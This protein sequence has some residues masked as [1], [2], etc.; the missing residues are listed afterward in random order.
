MR[1]AAGSHRWM[2]AFRSHLAM[3]GAVI[4]MPVVCVPQAFG[5]RKAGDIDNDG[6]PTVRDLT[7]ITRH[8]SGVTVLPEA[9]RIYA[10]VNSDGVVN[11]ADVALLIEEI[12]ETREPQALPPCHVLRASPLDGEGDVAVTRETVVH[13]SMPLSPDATLD[14][15]SFWAEFGGRKILARAEIASD[16]LKA[17]LFYLEPLPSNARVEVNLVEPGLLD[18]LGRPVDFNLD[19][20][21]NLYTT[22][23][24]TITITPVEG[25][26]ISGRVFATEIGEG[27]IETPLAGVT[28]TVDGAEETLRTTTDG[29][30]NFT[31]S[32]CPAGSFFVKIDGRTSPSSSY[33]NGDFY[34]VVAKKWEAIAGRDDNLAVEGGTIY[35]PLIQSGTLQPASATE[36]TVIEFPAEVV[37]ENPEL[38]GVTIEVPPNALFS[39][40]GTRGGLVGIAPVASDRLPEPLPSG[41]TH[42]IDISIQTDGG[43]NFDRPVPV[44]FPNLPDPETGERLPP[45]AKSALWS[46]NHDLGEWEISG[47]MTVTDDGMYLKSDPGVGVLQPGWHGT[48]PGIDITFARILEAFLFGQ[49]LFLPQDFRCLWRKNTL[50]AVAEEFGNFRG[51]PGGTAAFA[52]LK[53]YLEGSGVSLTYEGLNNKTVQDVLGSTQ[54]RA[55]RS[56]VQGIVQTR[57]RAAHQIGKKTIDN[58]T[59]KYPEDIGN[60][61]FYSGELREKAL[62]AAFGGTQSEEYTVSNVV[63]FE[64]GSYSFQLKAEHG[65]RYEFDNDDKYKSPFDLFA[66]YLAKHCDAKPFDVKVI[67]NDFINGKVGGPLEMLEVPAPDSFG[68]ET[69]TSSFFMAYLPKEID[70]SNGVNSISVD[71]AGGIGLRNAGVLPGPIYFCVREAESKS[72]II[73]RTI[74]G[75]DRKSRIAV[76]SSKAYEVDIFAPRSG[77]IRSITVAPANPGGALRFDKIF[78]NSEP[79][80]DLIDS[81]EDLLSDVGESVIGTSP[82]NPD[83]DNDGIDDYTEVT[84]GTD[85]LSGLAARTGI[86]ASAP[87]RGSAID[88]AAA[89]NLAVTAN[90]AAGVTVFNIFAGLNPTRI[91]EVDTPGTAQRVSAADDLIAVADGVAGLAVV[92]VSD[93]PSAGIVHQVDLGSDAFSVATNGPIAFVGTGDGRVVRVNM[94]TGEIIDEATLAGS[95]PVLDLVIGGETLYA[96]RNTTLST[97]A[98]DQAELVV[99]HT[100]SA[101]ATVPTNNRWRRIFAT[102]E[103]L[104][105]NFRDGWQRFSLSNDPLLPQSSGMKVT[106]ARGWKQIVPNGSGLALACVGANPTATGPHHL[107]VYDVGADA[108]GTQ[109]LT[110]FETPGIAEAV[111]IANGLAYVADGIRGLQVVNYKAYDTLGQPPSVTLD[112]RFGLGAGTGAVDAGKVSRFTAT[113]ADDVQV[114]SVEFHI[115]D[116][117]AFTDVTYPFEHRFLPPS[118][119]S[120]FTIKARAVDTGGNAAWTDEYTISVLTE[121]VPPQLLP[122]SPA[123]GKV[124]PPK[125]S[126]TVRFSE[127]M[128]LVSLQNGGIRLTSAGPDG[129]FGTADDADLAPDEWRFVSEAFAAVLRFN[130]PLD[131]GLYRLEVTTAARDLAG[132]ALPAGS[133][134]EFRFASSL[135]SDNDGVPDDFESVL[136]LTVGE[137][138]SDL[139]GT[140]DG[141]ED[142]DNDGATNAEEYLLGFDPIDPDSDG[143]GVLDGSEDRDYDGLTDITELLGT[144]DFA[145]ADTDGDGFDDAT[146][147][148]AGMDPNG[149]NFLPAATSSDRVFILNAVPAPLPLLQVPTE[150][151]P[152]SFENQIPPP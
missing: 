61:N 131:P 33:P 46:F 59:L 38:A 41:L 4:A 31:L 5:Q 117:L 140:P 62:V 24:E 52:N 103:T 99:A 127:G 34:P 97:L 135:D 132:N 144:T 47:P 134:T 45:G 123:S 43:T 133:S 100:V 21:T 26:A 122:L 37:A 94:L 118:V 60:L 73:R 30:G 121:T 104:L 147:I 93:P 137:T 114:R 17:T 51:F 87:T 143:D 129:I 75:G 1:T 90:G 126:L 79:E 58:F 86:I 82:T 151:A 84:Q 112:S 113:V 124:L 13:F 116:E 149:T 130:A 40:D 8:A 67:T 92:D 70:I 108:L 66:N 105:I 141:D 128:D 74:L 68:L 56:L 22:T 77:S 42:T 28:I 3:I 102:P 2:N 11:D 85:P 54:Y 6:V 18:L 111:S 109:F 95:G 142:F 80:S 25:T 20:E 27:G 12:L 119:G 9:L 72:V 49:E 50:N 110:T 138:D 36:T 23:F 76:S 152:V 83:T 32:P 120:T 101:T 63:I 35:L 88:I 115:D 146:E 71:R 81:D 55:V 44:C 19:G 96:V 69:D 16:R 139:D 89:N 148:A 15:N 53:H 48:M 150:S 65:D 98:A 64:D 125:D 136:G 107:S 39:D 29:Q 57:V 91:A 10:D 7:S 106:G 145:K 14:T 78:L